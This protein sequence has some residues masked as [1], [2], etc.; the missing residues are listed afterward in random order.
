MVSKRS[1]EGLALETRPEEFVD[2]LTCGMH[3]IGPLLVE[4]INELV[5][6]CEQIG[7]F[8]M[9]YRDIPGL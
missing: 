6:R 4:L 3:N 9:K 5:L 1:L 2:Y 7:H 8:V